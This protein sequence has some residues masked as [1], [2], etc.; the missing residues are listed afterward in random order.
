[1]VLSIIVGGVDSLDAD[2]EA[3]L[4][5]AEP[6]LEEGSHSLLPFETDTANGT[7]ARVPHLE[8]LDIA[9]G[10]PHRSHSPAI[11]T[12]L[13]FKSLKSVRLSRRLNA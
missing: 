12:K 2:K 9:I 5:D 1:M 10:G 7:L 3:I 11:R 13:R 6:T 8:H 4:V